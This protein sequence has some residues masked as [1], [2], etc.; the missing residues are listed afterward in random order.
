MKNDPLDRLLR[1]ASKAPAREASALD[2]GLENR[3]LA[4]MRAARSGAETGALISILRWGLAFA[5]SAAVC[6]VLLSTRVN[7]SSSSIE[8]AFA[9][10]EPETY[11]ALQ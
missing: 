1:A 4:A 7:T 9:T 10:P 8:E 5:G 3:V 6:M 2:F 11:L